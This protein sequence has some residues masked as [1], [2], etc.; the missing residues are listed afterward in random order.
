MKKILVIEDDKYLRD[1]IVEKL[2]K[3]D[4]DVIEAV[5]GETGWQ[6][7]ANHHPDLVL[8]DIILPVLNGFDYLTRLKEQLDLKK[9]PVVILS[10]LGQAEDIERGKSL[11]AKDYII[12]AH[13]TPDDL[14]E[15]IRQ[16]I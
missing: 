3:E 1:V 4:Y 15:K 2:K 8:L 11:G 10:N 12:K 5:D 14:M 7:T 13:F 16:Y 6:L 9:I